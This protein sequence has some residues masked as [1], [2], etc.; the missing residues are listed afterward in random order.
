MPKTNLENNLNTPENGTYAENVNLVDLIDQP[1]WKSILLDLVKSEKM[2]P[3]AIDVGELADKYLAKIN[4]LEKAD[5]RLPANAILASAILLKFKAKS[6]RLTSLEEK[7]P[8]ISP[9]EIARMNAMIPDLTSVR[10]G[11]E[12]RVSLDELVNSIESIIEK[13]K[14]KEAKRIFREIPVFQLPFTEENLEEKIDLIFAKINERMDSQG[15]L[16][17]SALLDKNT[18]EERVNTF[19]PVLFL[20]NKGKI[21]AWQ[22][23]FFGEIFISLRVNG[24][25]ENNNEE[26][27]N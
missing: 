22:E 12:G 11:R 16:M 25:E 1:A 18:S 20:L 17:F 6:L 15:L 7:E 3:W 5:L 2:D 19:V 23:E 27:E 26:K 14:T 21:N 24:N 13:T 8:E 4:Q 9:E 10:R